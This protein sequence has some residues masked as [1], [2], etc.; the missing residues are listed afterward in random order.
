M[1]YLSKIHGLRG[2]AAE[3]ELERQKSILD[4]QTARYA[5]TR[6][7]ARFAVAAHMT[8]TET[9]IRIL[10]RTVAEDRRP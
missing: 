7:A 8:K 9:K 1:S 5:E 3:L 10:E 4:R 2:R 6:P